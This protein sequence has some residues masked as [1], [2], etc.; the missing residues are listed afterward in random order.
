MTE[1][2]GLAR[3]TR[4]VPGESRNPSI[5]GH[6]RFIASEGTHGV[7]GCQ[8]VAARGAASRAREG[9]IIR[10]AFVQTVGARHASPLRHHEATKG[11]K[12]TKKSRAGRCP[13]PLG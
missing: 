3:P 8:T 11:T 6:V 4:E 7:V 10:G 9:A 1:R 12:H 2:V 13:D 5:R